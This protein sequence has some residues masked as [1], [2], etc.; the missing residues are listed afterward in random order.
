MAV[1]NDVSPLKIAVW[2][3]ASTRSNVEANLEALNKVAAEAKA[4]GVDL[5]I[6]PEMFI[7][8]Y[9]IGEHIA[10]LASDQPLMRVSAIA[11][12]NGLAIIAGGPEQREDGRIANSAW[13]FDDQGTV[14]AKHRKLQLFGTIDRENFVAGEQPVTLATYRGV[15][16]ALL[17]CFDVEYPEATRAAAL[18][19]AELIAVP[20]AQMDPFSFVNE[21]MIR[22]RAWEN[23]V[24]VAYAN[25]V[26][27][28]ES[29]RYVGLSVIADPFGQHLAQAPASGEALI[30][31]TIEL[32]RN[33]AARQQNPYL[34]QIRRDLFMRS[35]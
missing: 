28:D 13:F 1:H 20:T 22:V 16:I 32:S 34:E 15:K 29:F 25:Q 7:T 3:A 10:R 12:Q 11:K 9:N 8:G 31:A 33:G 23:S 26:G 4:D 30:S 24:Y 17:I 21:H 6:T 2:Q 19:G 35:S 18:A 14:L 27:L 5:L